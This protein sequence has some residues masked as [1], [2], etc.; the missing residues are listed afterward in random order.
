MTPGAVPYE[1][2]TAAMRQFEHVLQRAPDCC[3][4]SIVGIDESTRQ[5]A[6]I[7]AACH[8]WA[9]PEC[10][11]RK[12]AEYAHRLF[13][14]EPERHIVL[15][16][17]P[18]VSDDPQQAIDV[19]KDALRKLAYRI[20]GG[21]TRKDGSRQF[22][23]YRFEYA[24]IWELHVNGFPHIHIAQW[25]D[26]IPHQLLRKHWNALTGATIVYIKSMASALPDAHHWTKYLLKAIPATASRFYRMRMIS[27][28][29]RYDR[30]GKVGVERALDGKF[31][32][33]YLKVCPS[34]ILDV[35]VLLYKA[36][37]VTEEDSVVTFALPHHAPPNGRASLEAFF[38]WTEAKRNTT[39]SKAE[40]ARQRRLRLALSQ[41]DQALLF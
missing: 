11:A 34:E 24:A 14:A 39:T 25:G 20:R 23:V 30:N 6:V 17:D 1:T 35:L 38:D 19:M 13:K 31:T 5:V 29:A 37:E 28:S 4:G 8:R 2:T 3:R 36:Q 9:C 41:E 26:Y 22:P 40:Y 32:W 12:A 27:F 16:W 33:H 15:T 21:N 18:K 7:P 10:A